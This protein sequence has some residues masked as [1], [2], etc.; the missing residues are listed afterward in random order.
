MPD[1]KD[2]AV[3][4]KKVYELSV[5]PA[6]A[7]EARKWEA[8][9]ILNAVYSSATPEGIDKANADKAARWGA[10]IEQEGLLSRMH[11]KWHLRTDDG[12]PPAA[13]HALESALSNP[14][15]DLRARL[16]TLQFIAP[17]DRPP[18]GDLARALI[19]D[20]FGGAQGVA[21]Q[22]YLDAVARLKTRFTDPWPIVLPSEGEPPPV[23]VP[24]EAGAPA[25]KAEVAGLLD[26]ASAC[27]GRAFA[28]DPT[29]AR[30]LAWIAGMRQHGEWTRA[31]DS[32]TAARLTTIAQ[33]VGARNVGALLRPGLWL[34][35][36]RGGGTCLLTGLM[37]P[38]PFAS[39]SWMGWRIC[40]LICYDL[41]F[42]AWSRNS[43]GSFV[44]GLEPLYDLLIYVANWPSRRAHH[45]RSL[46]T[47]RAIENQAFV[48]G[49]NIVGT[50]GAGLE[51]EG[52]SAVIDF[53]GAPFFQISGREDVLTAE[54]SL[55]NLQQYRRQLP[56]LQDADVFQLC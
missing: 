33:H 34:P 27:R 30:L 25:T 12:K 21:R 17:A 11:P 24:A 51:Y 54:L 45:W 5:L 40:P 39:P 43:P 18:L 42:P 31:R 10:Q 9:L 44:N 52:D 35:G 47:A 8:L 28:S 19:T 48:A 3:L 6:E 36:G 16:A 29:P 37:R 14:T 15:R 26:V 2:I 7:L 56:F 13:R 41:R 38:R 20:A 55:D 50:D 22:Q 46:L 23:A 1:N 4:A 53:G 32:L 49:V